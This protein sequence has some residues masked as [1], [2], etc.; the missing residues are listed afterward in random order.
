MNMKTKTTSSG[1]PSSTV[2]EAWLPNTLSA[3]VAAHPGLIPDA[4]LTHLVA[5][6]I[7]LPLWINLERR[8]RES[9]RAAFMSC[10]DLPEQTALII[11]IED[12]C[13]DSREKAWD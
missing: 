3:I 11:A 10:S 6:H 12:D 9:V 2:P 4:A 5:S 1:G 7:T 13:I 8:E